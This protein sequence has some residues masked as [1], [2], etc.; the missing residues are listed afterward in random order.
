MIEIVFGDSACGSLK[1]AQHYYGIGKFSSSV[2]MFVSCADG[3]KPSEEDILAARKEYEEKERIEWERATPMGGNPTD[4]YG[5]DYHLSVGDISEDVPGEK[6]RQVLERYY[7]IFPDVDGEPSFTDEMMRRGATVLEEVCTRISHGESVRIW[8]SNQPDEICGMYWFITQISQFELLDGQVVLVQH[9][10]WEIR[11]D[12]VVI[13]QSGWGGVSPG[14]WHRYIDLQQVASKP[15]FIYCAL[16][17][18]RLQ[19]E[20]CPL[21]AVL[22]GRPGQ[23]AGNNI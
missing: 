20:N 9:P 4:V 3:S 12:G 18:R 16:Q 14:E 19:Q 1:Q 6:R 5:F 8:Y 10:D 2:G 22:N 13:T 17:W 11:G 15:F 21:R 7:S 23:C